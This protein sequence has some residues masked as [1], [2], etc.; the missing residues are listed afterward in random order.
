[1]AFIDSE[2]KRKTAQHSGVDIKDPANCLAV[3]TSL[4]EGG[5]V[6]PSAKGKICN[7]EDIDSRSYLK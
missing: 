4:Q 1:M 3:Q 7:L 2:R 5:S 6:L